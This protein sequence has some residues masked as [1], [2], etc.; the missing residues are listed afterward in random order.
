MKDIS[1]YIHWPFCLSKCPYCD[2]NSHVFDKIDHSEWHKGLLR[3]VKSLSEK[4]KG[5]KL[6]SIFFGGGT[7]SLMEPDLVSNLISES[8]KI[9]KTDGSIEI[10]L[11]ANPS[12]VESEKFYLF[13]EAG[14]NRISLGVQS[15]NDDTLKFLGREH[16]AFDSKKA[17]EIA[18]KTFNNVSFDMIYAT[19]GQAP[20]NWI[21]ELRQAIDFSSEHLSVYQLTIERGTAF[22]QRYRKGEFTMLNDDA[23]ADLY[24]ITHDILGEAG[25]ADYEISNHSKPGYECIHNLQYWEMKDYLGI[26]AGAHSRLTDEAGVRW[27]FR[28][29]RGPNRWLSEIKKRGNAVVEKFCLSLE[30]QII[31]TLMMGLRLRRGISTE[32]FKNTFNKSICDVITDD[33]LKILISEGLVEFNSKTF[34]AT[35][36]GRQKLD[37]VVRFLIA[38]FDI[39][40][41]RSLSRSNVN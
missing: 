6:K 4:T 33:P 19:P 14:I 25:L 41:H 10:S 7:P 35:A 24:E 23:L 13:K 9:W 31:E 36:L 34:K 18:K 40:S 39:K 26:G 11:E 27:A 2:F 1:L 3:E 8:K 16:D 5:R 28:T 22:F 15:F 12:S 37:S 30:E 32:H 20:Q 38:D 21:S 29:H 17:I